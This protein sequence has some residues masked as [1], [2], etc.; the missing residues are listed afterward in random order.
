V[1]FTAGWLVGGA[2]QRGGYSAA[3]DYMSDEAALTADHPWIMLTAQ[4]VA[5]VL[6]IAFAVLALRRSLLVPGHRTPVSAW[7]VAASGLGLDNL[8]DAFFRLDCRA[9]DAQCLASAAGASWHA[10]IHNTV[11][12]LTSLA[13][14]IA[15]F[16]LARRFTIAPAWRAGFGVAIGFGLAIALGIGA[17]LV[18]DDGHGYAQR[19]VRLVAS[20]GV[21]LLA[22]RGYRLAARGPD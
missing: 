7:L 4:G 2:V 9:V 15:P 8:S 21:V 3:R 10:Q 18:L 19:F 1:I 13:T 11:G 12:T 17:N 6:T 14:L 16:A 22:M 20:M 5:G